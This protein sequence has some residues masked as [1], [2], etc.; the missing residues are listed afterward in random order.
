[1]FLEKIDTLFRLT[2]E[3]KVVFTIYSLSFLSVAGMIFFQKKH[4]SGWTKYILIFL[5]TVI[6]FRILIFN[7]PVFFKVASN[8]LNVE[9]IGWRENDALKT[10]RNGF[11]T[12]GPYDYLAIG[13]SQVGAVFKK[14]SGLNK[15]F[16]VFSLAGMGTLDYVLYQ[17]NI[18]NYYP[19]N[20]ILY[21]SDF[22]LCRKPYLSSAKLAPT[23]P[24]IKMGKLISQL[25]KHD[26]QGNYAELVTANFL[27]EYRYQYIF[28]GL[29]HKGFGKNKTFPH[30]DAVKTSK[31]ENLQ[32]Q[33]SSLEKLNSKWV[34]I[35][36]ELLSNF[37]K[38][39]EKSNIRVFIVEGHYH[40]KALTK[41]LILHDKVSKRI[42]ILTRTNKAVYIKSEHV[43]SF[44][45]D[46]YRD[47]YHVLV[48]A[49]YNFTKKLV[50]VIEH[51]Y[52]I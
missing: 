10:D 13:S 50:R 6:G 35:N 43:Y 52:T 46:D 22:D 40:P 29:L 19:R 37:L 39:C 17:Q 4:L 7:N 34:E 27:P 26:L 8:T 16:K 31:K 38:W 36:L 41:N 18:K 49:G 45:E 14:Y 1:M 15:N 30:Q 28:K 3:F 23:Q 32:I 2:S 44:S 21:L 48:K 47:G 33:L 25:W 42:E 20:I 24:I 12:W 51:G 5:I 9:D 11:F